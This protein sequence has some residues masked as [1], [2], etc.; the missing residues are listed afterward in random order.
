MPCI[1]VILP[2][3]VESEHNHALLIDYLAGFAHDL[4]GPIDV[5]AQNMFL[6]VNN[7]INHYYIIF[8]TAC[9]HMHACVIPHIVRAFR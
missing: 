3:Q 8:L 1:A 2:E 5:K 9:V 6:M 7:L 4:P